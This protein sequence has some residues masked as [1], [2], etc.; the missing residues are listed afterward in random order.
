MYVTCVC[1]FGCVC[2]CMHM[3]LCNTRIYPQTQT[4][5]HTHLP[6]QLLMS[7]SEA[8]S[9]AAEAPIE[10][11]RAADQEQPM[12]RQELQAE[13]DSVCAQVT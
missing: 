12:S 2:V 11:S 8:N 3:N 10:A 1:G 6:T 9:R 5:H 4:Y 13:L 7:A